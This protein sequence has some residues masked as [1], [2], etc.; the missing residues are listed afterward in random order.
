M[1]TLIILLV[2]LASAG[3]IASSA[4]SAATK[5]YHPAAACVQKLKHN[6]DGDD[7][8]Y[9]GPGC[10]WWLIYKRGCLIGSP[11]SG[12]ETAG[13]TV[14]FAGLTIPLVMVTSSSSDPEIQVAWDLVC[15]NGVSR[16]GDL[17]GLYSGYGTYIQ[18][19]VQPA[20]CILSLEGQVLDGGDG[21]GI[22]LRVYSMVG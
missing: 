10:R 16:S 4:S 3:V 7:S 13:E 1:K 12:D 2:A 9:D 22:T 21:D 15:A 14:R 8:C 19:D 5:N 17:T 20:A 6:Q 18:A 11:A